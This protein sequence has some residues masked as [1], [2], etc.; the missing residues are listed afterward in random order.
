MTVGG[1]RHPETPLRHPE[2]VSGSPTDLTRPREIPAFLQ[3]ERG[4][5]SKTKTPDSI[6][7]FKNEKK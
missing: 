2:L 4:K 5:P 6:R 3:A 1:L 7:H